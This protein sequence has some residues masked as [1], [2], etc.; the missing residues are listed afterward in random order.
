MSNR[1]LQD[2]SFIQ[3][4]LFPIEGDDIYWENYI[5]ENPGLK[6]EVDEAIRILKSVK[7]NTHKLSPEEKENIFELIQKDIRKRQKQKRLR[8]YLSVSAVA[9][10]ALLFILFRSVI[11]QPDILHQEILLSA[12]TDSIINHNDIQLVLGNKRTI[13]FGNDADIKYDEKGDIIV[14]TGDEQI[15][16]SKLETGEV[17]LNTLIVPKGKRSSL[18]LADGTKVWINSGS[19]LKFPTKFDALKR[20][21]W[22]EGEI[23]IE[24]EKDESRPFHVNTPRMMVEVVGTQFNVTAYNEDTEHSIVLVEGCV[25]VNTSKEKARLTPHQKLS[26]SSDKISVEKINVEDY[27]SW[28][29][30][31]L[32]FT[33]E[34]L[35]AVLKRLS[36]YYDIPIYAENIESIKCNGKLVLFD[37][38]EN[39]MITLYNTVPVEYS[40]IGNQIYIQKR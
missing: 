5:K 4:R 35:S 30:G 25:D 23:Y 2:K 40:F 7:L 33:S 1:L 20:D 34:P 17:S 26:Y 16:T 12:A 39:V 14:E 21:I 31:Y 3:W 22:V 28:K 29:E 13:T 38:I 36:R 9:C 27:I 32:Q 10:V 8:I 24:V 11:Y 37:D 6:D 19:V 15:K 18:T